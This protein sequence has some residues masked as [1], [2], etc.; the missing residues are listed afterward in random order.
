M[1]VDGS[2]IG[3]ANDILEGNSLLNTDKFIVIITE[4]KID[5]A[6]AT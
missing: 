3:V 6:K 2:D 4:L 1:V 5:R